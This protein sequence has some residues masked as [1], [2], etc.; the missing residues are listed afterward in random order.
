MRRNGSFPSVTAGLSAALEKTR[1][2]LGAIGVDS[3]AARESLAATGIALSPKP[4]GP[5][6][7]RIR[8]IKSAAEIA[9][10][11]KAASAN[12]AAARAAVASMRIGD[13]YADLRRAYFT[14]TGARGGRPAFLQIDSTAREHRDGIIHEGRAFMIDAV[15][16]YDRYHGDYGRT[17]SPSIPGAP[18]T[19]PPISSAMPRCSSR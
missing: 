13:S 10:M 14:E 3:A 12:C 8:H 1:L 2:S 16:S 11:R 18:G 4:A 9:L 6:L 15:S 7:R 17:T 5:A 19:R